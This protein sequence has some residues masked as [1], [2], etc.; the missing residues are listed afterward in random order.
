MYLVNRHRRVKQ[1]RDLCGSPRWLSIWLLIP[2]QVM[3]SESWTQGC[4]V[5]VFCTECRVCLS[6]SLSLYLSTRHTQAKFLSLPNKKY[7]KKEEICVRKEH[8]KLGDSEGILKLQNRGIW[9][10]KLSVNLYFMQNISIF[11]EAGYQFL[12]ET[13]I[14]SCLITQS[15]IPC[16][17]EG[18]WWS[19]YQA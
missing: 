9:L 19:F 10:L 18:V 5:E 11:K 4:E 14:L 15:G 13:H 1:R 7:I 6:L 2:A 12:A 17:M 3:I 8:F 16:N